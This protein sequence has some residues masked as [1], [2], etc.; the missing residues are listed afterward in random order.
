MEF[1]LH[2]FAIAALTFGNIFIIGELNSSILTYYVLLIY[3][4]ELGATGN[5]YFIYSLN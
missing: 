4:I 2:I 3:Q 1:K 5:F